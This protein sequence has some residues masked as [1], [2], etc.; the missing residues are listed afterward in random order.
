MAPNCK[1]AS[2]I[3]TTILVVDV[4]DDHRR[5]ERDGGRDIRGAL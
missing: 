1:G 2:E 3:L 5:E 4:A